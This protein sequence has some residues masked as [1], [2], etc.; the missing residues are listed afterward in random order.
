MVSIAYQEL[1]KTSPFLEIT[2][3]FVNPLFNHTLTTTIV[4]EKLSLK[5]PN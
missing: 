2:V 4:A 1:L 3:G 5:K